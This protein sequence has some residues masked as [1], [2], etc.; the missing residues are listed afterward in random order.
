[1]KLFKMNEDKLHSIKQDLKLPM[2]QRGL[3]MIGV[4]FLIIIYN[5]LCLF[6]YCGWNEHKEIH[7]WFPK[8]NISYLL[9]L[10]HLASNG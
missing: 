9:G 5:V 7:I 3:I 1:M 2:V 4:F 6:T 10:S 8:S